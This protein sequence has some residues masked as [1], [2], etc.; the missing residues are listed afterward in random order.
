MSTAT[1]ADIEKEFEGFLSSHNRGGEAYDFNIK[2]RT[3]RIPDSVRQRLSEGVINQVAEDLHRSDLEYFM[4]E[5]KKQFPWI[6]KWNQEG[7]SGGWLTI[8][9]DHAVLDDRGNIYDDDLPDA[10]KRLRDLYRI[11]MRVKKG[12][13]QHIA[14][15]Q[16]K[17][18]W[19]EAAP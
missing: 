17:Q 12:V 4:E 10:R 15:L 1:K 7:R 8:F 9:P 14:T 16:S 11:E 2:L 18:F 6:H 5:L 19:D 13:K 3:I